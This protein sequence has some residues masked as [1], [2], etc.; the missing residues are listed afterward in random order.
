MQ[1]MTAVIE[2][3]EREVL[4]LP[5]TERAFLAD[6]LLSSLGSEVLGDI[7]LAWVE[8]NERF[9]VEY[10]EGKRQTVSALEVFAEADRLLK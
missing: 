5:D 4:S 2:R 6:R 1:L 7:D 3:I 9:Y 10:K 8:E